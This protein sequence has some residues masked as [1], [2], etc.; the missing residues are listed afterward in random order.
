V[1]C[2]VAFALTRRRKALK[3]RRRL[4]VVGQT[5]QW[6]SQRY[7]SGFPH[8]VFST[9]RAQVYTVTPTL[10]L[11]NPSGAN[12]KILL[13]SNVKYNSQ[14][15]YCGLNILAEEMAECIILYDV[16]SHFD[17]ERNEPVAWSQNVWKTR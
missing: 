8:P 14:F 5:T 13:T 15:V 2:Y 6:L 1:P 16:R 7:S 17:N 4:V 9:I 10:L 11:Q 3:R 12:Y